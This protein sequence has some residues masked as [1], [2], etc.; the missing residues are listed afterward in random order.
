MA[1]VV[2][3]TRRAGHGEEG[4]FAGEAHAQVHGPR[5]RGAGPPPGFYWPGALGGVHSDGVFFSAAQI[6]PYLTR[7]FAIHQHCPR[8]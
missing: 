4:P 6:R 8:P 3:E 5:F 1:I 7:Q 2:V